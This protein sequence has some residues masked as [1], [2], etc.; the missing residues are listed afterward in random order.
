MNLELNLLITRGINVK[1]MAIR[2]A[3]TA[4]SVPLI[5]V[6]FASK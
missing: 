3:G 2:M 6:M 1:D 4:P 5:L